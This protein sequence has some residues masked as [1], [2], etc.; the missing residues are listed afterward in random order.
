MKYIWLALADP[1]HA[2]HPAGGRR[3]AALP[4]RP[5]HRCA[6][7][8]G[9][10]CGPAQPHD[11]RA[12]SVQSLV[13]SL[14][15]GAFTPTLSHVTYGDGV[16]FGTTYTVNGTPGDPASRP[17][18][19]PAGGPLVRHPCR[20]QRPAAH[21]PPRP[22]RRPLHRRLDF[23]RTHLRVRRPSTLPLVLSLSPRTCRTCPPAL[24]G[25]ITSTVSSS[26]ITV[27]P[28]GTIMSPPRPISTISTSGGRCRSTICLPTAGVPAPTWISAR[29]LAIVWS[30]ITYANGEGRGGVAS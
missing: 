29:S 12:E 18:P 19:F 3:L 4:A 23:A 15:P 6:G 20:S 9:R 27:L 30:R 14:R 2:C 7:A 5:A 24:A 11:R 13:R 28:R 10:L 1:A 21:H 16:Y 26:S 22:A 17:A 25:A 8:A